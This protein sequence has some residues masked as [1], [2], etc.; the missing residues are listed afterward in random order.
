MEWLNYQHL[1][2]FWV[3]AREG[4]I[5]AASEELRLAPSTISV[6]LKQLSE[7]LGH[8]LFERSG[9]RLVLSEMGR[10]VFRYADAICVTGRELLDFV[11]GHQ[12]GHA[13]RL[14]VGVAAVVPKLLAHQFISPAFDSEEAVHVVVREDRQE[15]LLAE[16]AMHR[17]DIVITD[18]AIGPEARVKVFTH[19]LGTCGVVFFATPELRKSFSGPFPGCLDGQPFLV[20]TS[21]NALRRMLDHWF[22]ARDIHPH[23][24]GEYD[25][26]AL[27]KAA[28]Q[29]GHGFFAAP[30][31]IADAIEHQ[32]G[33]EAIGTADGLE[34]RFY[35][36]SMERKLRHPAVARIKRSAAA[37]FSH[38]GRIAGRV[39]GEE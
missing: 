20:P 9:R 38:S 39:R 10:Q 27:L 30:D 18:S 33:V 34:E 15:R 5:R 16:L 24:I 14:D 36:V 26:S 2:Y 1:H 25:D 23:I 31:V 19:P 35:A 12:D 17:L 13:Q 21:D 4:S 11:H 6:Q 28:G 7:Q 32:Y 29:H 3:V 22:D 37:L 8:D